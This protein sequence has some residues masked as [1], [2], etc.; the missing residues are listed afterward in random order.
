MIKLWNIKAYESCRILRK[1][2]NN[3]VAEGIFGRKMNVVF[4]REIMGWEVGIRV[5][6]V[7]TD[8][9]EPNNTICICSGTA[10]TLGQQKFWNELQELSFSQRQLRENANTQ[11]IHNIGLLTTEELF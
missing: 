6:V 8:Q 7:F 11:C 1:D 2:S 4:K 3:F 9:P 5:D 10:A